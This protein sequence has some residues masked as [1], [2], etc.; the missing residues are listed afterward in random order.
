VASR[1]VFTCEGRRY[2]TGDLKIREV[3]ELERLLGVDYTALRAL[4]VM[5][6]K[7]AVMAVLLRRD[8]AEDVVEKILGDLT[9]DA[10]EAMWTVEADDLPTVYEDGL[11]LPGGE[12]ST[13]SS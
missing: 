13:S 4:G 8:H 12:P 10:V 11:P 2:H 1:L 6:H 5:R 9:L 7:I 3:E